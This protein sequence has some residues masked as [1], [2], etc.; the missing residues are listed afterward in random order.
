MN[1]IKLFEAKTCNSTT[2][3]NTVKFISGVLTNKIATQEIEY[4][5]SVD[6]KKITIP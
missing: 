2:E 6:N 3:S 1:F 5:A 4:D